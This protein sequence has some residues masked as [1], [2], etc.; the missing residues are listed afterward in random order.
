M[1]QKIE[2]AQHV[3]IQV[4]LANTSSAMKISKILLEHSNRDILSADDI[5]CGL[6]YRL[7]I[8]MSENE[9]KDSMETANDIMCEESSDGE[10]SDDNYEIVDDKDD[11]NIKREIKP[12]QCNCDICSQVRVCLHNF[13][14]YIPK[15]ELGDKFKK[16]IIDTCK[17]HNRII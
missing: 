14:D 8:P 2:K 15:D 4:I 3:L 11:L 5:I 10:Y 16:T 12:N 17:S 6:I 13:N 7:M 1:D 9:I